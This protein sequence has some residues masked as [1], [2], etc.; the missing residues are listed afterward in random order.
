FGVF[1]PKQDNP[2]VGVAIGDLIVDL[3]VLEELGHFRSPEF[4]DRHVFSQD[5]LNAFLALGRP[6]WRKTREIIQ[7]LLSAET[8]TLRDDA[9]LRARVFHEQK[10]VVMRLPA[11]IGDYTDFYS[12]YHHAHNVGT[13]LRGPEN[14]LMPN[15]KWLPVAYHGRASSVVVSGTD[16]RRPQGQI[17][18]PDAG[19][20][21]FG[22]TKSLDYELEMAFLIGP[23]NSL[24]QPVPIERALDHI[25]GFVLMNDWSARDIR[26]EEQT[27]ELQSRVDLVCR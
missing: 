1:Q 24:G 25:F 13:M 18:P 12:S 6:A 10:D 21:L 22:P 23:G 15:W 7:H 3:S 20:P 9:K 17:K 26:S 2:R 11:R 5:S 19:A 27:S 8:S 14:A 16:V 4:H